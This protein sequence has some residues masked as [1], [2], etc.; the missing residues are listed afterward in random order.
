[1]ELHVLHAAKIGHYLR[2]HVWDKSEGLNVG[3][4]A[5]SK[6]LDFFLKLYRAF[7][8]D[9]DK[10]KCAFAFH[11]EFSTGVLLLLNYHTKIFQMPKL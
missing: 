9:V 7:L 5:N 3:N 8:R 10:N 2:K 1:M 6:V 4:S 11:R